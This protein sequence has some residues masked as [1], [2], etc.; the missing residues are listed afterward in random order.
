MR[1]FL[2]LFLSPIHFLF[3]SPIHS[4]ISRPALVGLFSFGLLFKVPPLLP[5]S[6]LFSISLSLAFYFSWQQE[7]NCLHCS[8]FITICT[9]HR[10][11]FFWVVIF[12][13]LFGGWKLLGWKYLMIYCVCGLSCAQA[14]LDH[15][16]ICTMEPSENCDKT[17]TKK[18]EP[19]VETHTWNK[20]VTKTA[21]GSA[22]KKSTHTHGHND[23]LTLT[24]VFRLQAISTEFGSGNGSFV[25][26]SMW[27][28]PRWGK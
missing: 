6:I 18:Y 13:L 11:V 19:N 10:T 5:L 17:I 8:P 22:K 24:R 1:R 3:L 4:L 16:Y 23:I 25:V 7:A 20:K 14:K 26:L 12:H 2:S 9:S 15:V 27:T 21:R 28:I